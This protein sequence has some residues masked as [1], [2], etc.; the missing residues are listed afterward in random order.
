MSRVL[1]ASP[2]CVLTTGW[3]HSNFCATVNPLIFDTAANAQ[4]LD[5]MWGEGVEGQL[6]LETLC[7]QYFEYERDRTYE[8]AE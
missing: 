1:P 6:S 7:R 8:M 4:Q 5:S 3:L 2:R